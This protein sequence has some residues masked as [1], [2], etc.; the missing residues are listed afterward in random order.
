[1][2]SL[3]NTLLAGIGLYVSQRLY[4]MYVASKREHGLPPGPPTLPF[5]GN[6]HLFPRQQLQFKFTEWGT[7]F[8]WY[9]F[10]P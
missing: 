3:L 6:L 2:P 5:I 4:S 7:Y 8:A 1:M 9:S 10:K